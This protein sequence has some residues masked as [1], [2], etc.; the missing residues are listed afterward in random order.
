MTL[1]LRTEIVVGVD[2]GPGGLRAAEYAAI[3]AQEHGFAVRLVHAYQVVVMASP[4]LVPVESLDTVRA[5]AVGALRAATQRVKD[6]APGVEIDIHPVMGSAPAALINAS[7]NAALVV[8]GRNPTHG[9]GRMLSGS[10]STPVAARSRAPVVSV[11]A[12]WNRDHDRATVVVGTDGSEQGRAALAFAFE[13][14]SRR[15]A[16]L[17]A[18]RA[19]AIPPSS[20]FEVVPLTSEREG[21]HDVVLSLAEDLVAYDERYPDVPVVPVVERSSSPA[22]TLVIHA[23]GASLLVIGARAHGGVPGL[24]MGMVARNVLAHANVPVA[25][26]HRA[27]L[28][29]EKPP[30]VGDKHAASTA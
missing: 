11:P 15:H 6:T 23:C 19:W 29:S 8:V 10:T 1:T 26:V 4:A 14:A 3:R 24:E 16:P 20:A 28:E 2:G 12:G 25:V 9:L 27:D 7:S 18:V 13:E 30:A 17:T 5:S 21:L 22:R